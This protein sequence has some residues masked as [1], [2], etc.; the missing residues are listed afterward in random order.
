MLNPAFYFLSTPV[1]LSAIGLISV[2]LLLL[3]KFIQKR[4][5]QE[6]IRSLKS[7]IDIQERERKRI[8]E[9]IHDQIGPM[10]SAIKLKINSIKHMQSMEEVQRTVAET[11]SYI[12]MLMKDVRK[13]I[14]NLSPTNISENGFIK[15]I[16][17]FKSVVERNDIEFLVLHEGVENKISERAKLNLYRIISEMIN[18]SIKHSGCTA[19][20]VIMKM[21]EHSTLFLYVDNGSA[22]HDQSIQ[23]LGMGL[24]NIQ[25]RVASLQG[26][27]YCNEHFGDGAFY[28]IL[29]DNHALLN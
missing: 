2:C 24:K 25:S 5:K 12:D 10:I 18:N 20:K 1:Y 8:A 29:F 11:S 3:M 17:D 15:S 23:S 6:E 13:T 27:L 16:H 26:K 9:D 21:Y 7:A 4:K 22:R 28:Q 14:R 19:I